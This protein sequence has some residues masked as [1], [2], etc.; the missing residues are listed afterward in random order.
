MDFFQSLFCY[1]LFLLLFIYIAKTMIS[2]YT[3]IT[4]GGASGHMKHPYDYTDFTL[5]DLKGL[6]RN[7][8]SGRIEDITEKIDGTNIQATMN[9]KG[10]VVFIRNKTNLNSEIGGMTIDDMAEKWKGNPGIQKTFLTGGS[11]ITQVFKKIGPKFFNP[12][13]N[14]K[15]VLNCECVVEGKTNVLYYKS[16]QVDFHDIWVYEK[17]ENGEW[18]NTDVTKSGLDVIEKAAEDVDGAQITPKVIVK[19]TDESEKILVEYIKKIDRIFKQAGCKE[20]DTI[21]DWKFARFVQYCKDG[22]E[23]TDWVLKSDEGTKLLFN[24]WFNGDKSVNIKEIKKLYPENENDLASVDKKEYGKWI[25]DVMEPIDSFFI[26]LG[27]AIIELCDG[28][29]NADNK[30]EVVK[31]LKKD[32]EDAVNTVRQE[33][34][35]DANQ[36]L[37]HQL[38]RLEEIGLNASEGIVFRYKGK[39]QKLTG[40]FAA[41]NQAIGL[42]Y[43]K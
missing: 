29:L 2:L 9:P 21:E 8:F 27:N 28:I 31:Q 4:E 1:V 42:Q 7:L 13:P 36:K 43:K 35:E 41:L 38:N 12:S 18:E 19:T 22:D 5:R 23:W 40:S 11:I 34:S 6:I 25:S 39:L 16:S 37:T 33:G 17:D 14:K 30:A 32:L 15:L 24:R 3:Y 20:M 10:Q 26:G